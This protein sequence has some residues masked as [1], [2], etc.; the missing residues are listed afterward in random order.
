MYASV[1]FK[2]K[3]NIYIAYKA[4]PIAPTSPSLATILNKASVLFS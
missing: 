4:N 1:F 3:K 2:K